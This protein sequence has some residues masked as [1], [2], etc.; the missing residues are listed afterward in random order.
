MTTGRDRFQDHLGYPPRLM[1][2]DRAA[3]YVG[4]RTTKFKKLI[5]EGKM[6]EAIDVCGS[7]RWDRVDL[8]AAVDDLKDRRNDPV[9]RSRDRLEKRL[10]EQEHDDEN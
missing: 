6:P 1:S 5:G 4:F 2:L 8:D 9:K 3:T 7:P 10:S